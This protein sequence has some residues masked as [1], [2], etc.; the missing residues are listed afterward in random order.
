MRVDMQMCSMEVKDIRGQLALNTSPIWLEKQRS[1]LA[2]IND[3]K[4]YG[5]AL[6]DVDAPTSWTYLFE[7]NVDPGLYKISGDVLGIGTYEWTR[8]SL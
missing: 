5:P 1:F 7:E 6:I 8:M 4:R 2:E 3:K